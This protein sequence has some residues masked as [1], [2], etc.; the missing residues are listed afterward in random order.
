MNMAKVEHPRN[1]KQKVKLISLVYI[2]VYFYFEFSRYMY[3]DK[4]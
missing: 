3:I 1:F 4:M 2:P